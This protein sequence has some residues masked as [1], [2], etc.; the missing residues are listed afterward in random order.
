MVA[1]MTQGS[2]GVDIRHTCKVWREKEIMT[3]VV[4]PCFTA[5]HRVSQRMSEPFFHTV[6]LLLARSAVRQLQ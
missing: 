3:P 1:G 6:L 4:C 2:W 5:M